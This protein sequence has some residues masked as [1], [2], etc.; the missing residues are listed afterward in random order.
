MTRADTSDVDGWPG[1]PGWDDETGQWPHDLGAEVELMATLVHH[2]HAVDAAIDAGWHP[3][4]MYRELHKAV[5]MAILVLADSARV[6]LEHQ[7][8]S[9]GQLVDPVAIVNQIGRGHPWFASSMGGGPGTR[10]L[11]GLVNYPAAPAHPGTAAA[12]VHD[13][14]MRR[15]LI[16]GGIR[17]VQAGR[18]L[19][20][21]V[22]DGLARSEADLAAVTAGA[23]E[24]GDELLDPA[25]LAAD[26]QAIAHN[27]LLR[28]MLDRA[29]KVL[30][31]AAEGSGK[32]MI[33]YQLAW[34]LAIGVH[35]FLWEE[36]IDPCRALFVDLEMNR[37]M[38]ARRSRDMLAA[39]KRYGADTSG[40]RVWH[41][42]AGLDLRKP[43]NQMELIRQVR[44]HGPRLVA[45]GPMYKMGVDARQAEGDD[46]LRVSEFLDRLRDRYGCALWLEQHA[47]LP[48]DG[49]AREM[50]PEGTNLWLKWP[51]FGI[52]LIPEPKQGAN[53]FRW[54]HYRRPREVRTWPEYVY[55]NTGP[56][57]PWAAEYDP[58][59]A[60]AAAAAP[61]LTA[62]AVAQGQLEAAETR[63]DELAAR[64]A[65]LAGGSGGA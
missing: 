37:G 54:H 35:P 11:A 12:T 21:P 23:L 38:L 25:A 39:A 48:K 49:R 33:G 10:L 64:R 15:R 1:E 50:R 45:A 52:A 13:L 28:G 53:W 59:E 9:Y 4:D 24:G 63:S 57:W 31:V 7:G 41:R 27:W 26:T 42:P 46:F 18:T 17:Q 6:D 3:N 34:C 65:G 2:P 29:D 5:A 36:R 40:I 14:A 19:D 47:P 8:R 56:G 22:A 16:E 32:S 58:R 55:W 61:R 43:D 62:Q 51:D 44:K 30:L 60:P 20:L